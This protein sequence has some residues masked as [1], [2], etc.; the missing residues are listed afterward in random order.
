[1]DRLGLNALFVAKSLAAVLVGAAVVAFAACS[2]RFGLRG[3]GGDLSAETYIYNPDTPFTNQAIFTH[4]L[5]GGLVMI[6]APLQL[7]ARVR[8]DYPRVHRLAGRLV[9][10]AAIVVS[11][12]G[13][14]YIVRH[15]TIAGPLMDIGFALYGALMAVAAVQTIRFAR[16][17]DVR[18]H[19]NW[20][21]RLLVLLAGSL[22]YRLHYVFWYLVTGGLWSNE[23][24]TGPFDQVQYFA[25][26]LPYLA[27]LEIWIRRRKVVQRMQ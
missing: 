21:L 2:M 20:A 15:G 26:Y 5:L 3:L 13:F 18:R 25:F 19:N 1:M 4:M 7:I 27:L 10:L 16:K 17:G 6:L 11:F 22:I 23:Q 12:G 9:V 8:H 14:I 24:L